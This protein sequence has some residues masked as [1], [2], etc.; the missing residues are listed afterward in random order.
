MQANQAEAAR[1]DPLNSKSGFHTSPE[2]PKLQRESASQ[3]K[4]RRSPSGFL[5]MLVLVPS[6]TPSLC[7]SR[8][9][10]CELS[11]VQTSSL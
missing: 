8:A 9:K 10:E 5:S 6:H 4:Q 3:Y 2:K 11:G 1:V 7:E